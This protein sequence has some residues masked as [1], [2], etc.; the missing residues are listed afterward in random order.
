MITIMCQC[1]AKLFVT[2]EIRNI[3]YRYRVYRVLF[4]DRLYI[5][6]FISFMI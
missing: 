6:S 4:I 1:V 3:V 5:L 2:E